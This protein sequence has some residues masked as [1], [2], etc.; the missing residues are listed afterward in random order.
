[1]KLRDIAAHLRAELIGDGDCEIHRVAK[2]EEAGPGDLTFLANPKYARHLAETRASAVIAG[3]S[4]SLPSERSASDLA[5]LRV[6]DPYTS[7]VRAV[8]L[9]HPPAPPVQPGIHPSAVIDQ[10]AVLG[11][12]VRVAAGVVIGSRCRIGERTMIAPG[13]VIGDGASIGTDC[14]LYASSVVREQCVLG[15]RVILQPG[16]IVGGDGFGFAPLPD[17]TYEKIPQVGIVV[18]EDDVEIGA[19]TT[20]DRA[21][22]GETR[23]KK[24]VKLDNLIQVA[25]NVV[26]GEHTVSAAQ[27]GI[28]GSTK[29]GKNVMIGGQVGFTGHI[30]IADGT[31]IGAQSGVHRSVTKPNTILFGYPAVPQKE[32]F[33]IQGAIAQLPEL[34]ETIRKLQNEVDELRK[35]LSQI[36]DSKSNS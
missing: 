36:K 13:V 8:V 21:T 16:V 14:I 26:I 1:V 22:I 3:K 9:F 29:I 20:I 6:D 30:E 18:I 17:G 5:L 12:D 19:N 28:S 24:G 34:L 2:I 10:T 33:K 15:N 23:V 31:K 25:H 7:F 32:A 27:A 4:T 11:S 35:R